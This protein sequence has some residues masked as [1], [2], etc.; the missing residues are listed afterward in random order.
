MQECNIRINVY[1]D[2]D[3]ESCH[4]VIKSDNTRVRI[5][6]FH[7]KRFEFIVCISCLNVR[8]TVMFVTMIQLYVYIH[9][10]THFCGF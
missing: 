4:R 9:T 2:R 1:V 6:I 5:K 10:H 7:F 3:H 8:I